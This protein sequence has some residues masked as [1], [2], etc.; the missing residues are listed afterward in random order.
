M[1]EVREDFDVEKLYFF[2]F[3]FICFKIQFAFE[4]VYFVYVDNV[5][6]FGTCRYS[7]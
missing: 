3:K 2:L 5:G 4:F 1:G 7:N 6:G